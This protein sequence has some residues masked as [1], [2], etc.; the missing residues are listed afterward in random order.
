MNIFCPKCDTLILTAS[1]CPACGWERPP[2]REARKGEE[3]WRLPLAEKTQSAPLVAND[4]LFCGARDGKV[5]AVDAATCKRRWSLQLPEGWLPSET[6]ACA[7]GI[8]YVGSDDSRPLSSPDK[9][10]LALD[11]DSGKELWR[12]E[13][14]A[15]RLSAP[16]FCV[17]S[18]YFAASDGQ[19][20]AVDAATGEVRWRK[21]LPA[22]GPAA[23]ATERGLLVF[24]SRD[25]HLAAL[26][27]RSGRRAW[28]FTISEGPSTW[29]PKSPTLVE[30]V[31]YVTSWN[32]HLYAVDATTGVEKWR[33][34]TQRAILTAPVTH[35]DAVI[36]GGQDHHLYVVN[37]HSGELLWKKDLVRRVYSTPVV[38]DG[39]VY[40][41]SDSKHIYAF[42]VQS[43]EPIWPQPLAVGDRV[44][45]DLAA[46]ETRLYAAS[47][48]G[49]LLAV[50]I[51]QPEPAFSPAEHEERGEWEQAAAAYA[52]QGDFARAAH[53]HEHRL[54]QPHQ[55]AQLYQTAGELPKAAVLFVQVGKRRDALPLFQELGQH[56]EAAKLAEELDRR[57]EAAVSWEQAGEFARAAEIYEALGQPLKAADLY[58][59]AGGLGNRQKARRLWRQAGKRQTVIKSHL[60]DEEWA[61]AAAL[62]AEAGEFTRAAELY[63]QAGQ[64]AQAARMWL[65]HG[66]LRQAAQAY[67]EAGEL[68]KAAALY[69]ELTAW[70]KARDLY[71]R[72]GDHEREAS[73]CLTMGDKLGA[74]QVYEEA[75]SRMEAETQ[76]RQEQRLAELYD[77]AARLY[78]EEFQQQPLHR[79]QQKVT[80]YRKLPDVKLVLQQR[81][82]FVLG[83]GNVLFLY[84]RNEGRD[85]ARDIHIG[86]HSRTEQLT[87][88]LAT[89]VKG[90]GRLTVQEDPVTL[91]VKPLEAGKLILDVEMSYTDRRDNPYSAR[92]EWHI[93]VRE[94]ED[95]RITPSEL[96]VHGTAYM[97]DSISVVQG[98]QLL[99]GAQ[100][101]DKVVIARG[102][103]TPELPELPRCPH[104]DHAQAPGGRFCEHCGREL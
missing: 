32:G 18:V 48:Y 13:T 17:D 96:H 81:E 87:G 12:V 8:V 57:Q 64:L 25:R 70:P 2:E 59:Q 99:P 5:H 20:Y 58:V 54:Q 46:D 27:G 93:D 72:L 50:T 61:E 69:C 71:Q 40:A 77:R 47:R 31:C 24:G 33:F 21:P 36:F 15:L 52:L 56:Q 66:D 79:C 76:G 89:F 82:P 11:A 10:L 91:N 101:G 34:G 97:G 51:Q 104:C 67:E 30:E 9:A 92:L 39:V 90:L 38:V 73:C 37:R 19:A 42:D 1:S 86:V 88:Q 7:H 60:G 98:D 41:T 22:W 75:A 102:A 62:Y 6:L 14:T 103:P 83:H 53:L 28:Q 94:P 55:A 63:G 16:R 26:Y 35:G 78:G 45:A 29:L 68:A 95:T 84:P 4:S 49:D 65:Q 80:Y 100:K 3:L 85:F 43:G 44:R 74:A 23:P